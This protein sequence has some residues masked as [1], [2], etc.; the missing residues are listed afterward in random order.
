ME[1]ENATN[2]NVTYEITPT[3]QGLSV[4]DSGVVTWAEE[5]P[6]N[7]Y[8]TEIKTEDGNHTATHSLTLTDPEQDP[9]EPDP[10]NETEVVPESIEISPKEHTFIDIWE[11][12]TSKRFNVTILPADADQTFTVETSD[13]TVLRASKDGTQA[14]GTAM[15]SGT[16]TLSVKT[17]NGLTDTATINVP[18]Q[19]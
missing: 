7:V 16:A 8:V 11:P 18:E 13:E 9:E 14:V 1:P 17:I 10:A 19:G 6:A 2:K 15:T 3:A 12:G 5:T 4:S